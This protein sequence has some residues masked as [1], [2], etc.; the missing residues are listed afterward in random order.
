MSLTS[1]SLSALCL[2]SSAFLSLSAKAIY[3]NHFPADGTFLQESAKLWIQTLSAM[4]WDFHKTQTDLYIHVLSEPP[5][6][7]FFL[8]RLSKNAFKSTWMKGQES[9]THS[10]YQKSMETKNIPYET[11]WC[12]S[13]LSGSLCGAHR[14]WLWGLLGTLPEV[15]G[16]FLSGKDIA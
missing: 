4:F 1:L 3:S 8:L 6:V 16:I 11:P 14:L 10:F 2:C 7:L 15:K 5:M 9:I 12:I 13:S